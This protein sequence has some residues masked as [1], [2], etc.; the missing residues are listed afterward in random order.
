MTVQS[1][2]LTFSSFSA[3]VSSSTIVTWATL[4]ISGSWLWAQLIFL[5][6]GAHSQSGSLPV[7]PSLLLRLNWCC[8]QND[9]SS[10]QPALCHRGCWRRLQTRNTIMPWTSLPESSYCPKEIRNVKLGGS[11]SY[12]AQQEMRLTHNTS[13]ASVKDP[14]ALHTWM[15]LCCL[16]TIL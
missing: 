3:S 12:K 5:V 8:C 16:W 14:L 15:I 9:S 6:T 4:L 1:M 10:P 7:I 11:D 13:P 2:V